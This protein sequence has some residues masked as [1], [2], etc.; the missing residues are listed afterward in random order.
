MPEFSPKGT[1]GQRFEE[2]VFLALAAYKDINMRTPK[3]KEAVELFGED[4][5]DCISGMYKGKGSWSGVLKAAQKYRE[6]KRYEIT[7]FV[8]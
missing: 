4:V 7:N 3:R 6:G 8:P 5:V 1:P 2:M